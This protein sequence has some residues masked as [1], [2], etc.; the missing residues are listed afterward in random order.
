MANQVMSHSYRLRLHG[1][2]LAALRYACVFIRCTSGF[3]SFYTKKPFILRSCDKETVHEKS[4]RARRW[5]AHFPKFLEKRIRKSCTPRV[6]R[7]RIL[8]G[9]LSLRFRSAAFFRNIMLSQKVLRR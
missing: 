2:L 4:S 9:K 6:L 3:A 8:S 5:T 7:R 1:D